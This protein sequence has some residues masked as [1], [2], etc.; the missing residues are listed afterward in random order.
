MS[1][2]PNHGHIHAYTLIRRVRKLSRPG[3][4]LKRP[5]QP[6]RPLDVVA[7]AIVPQDHHIIDVTKR[8][9]VPKDKVSRYILK[10][11][12]ETV[13]VDE[14]IAAR[15]QIAGLHR[16]MVRSPIEGEVVEV[17]GGIIILEG[18]PAIVEVKASVTGEVA[19]VLS[20]W[21]VIVET[22]GA[23]LQL[24]WA[25]GELTVS[26]LKI[27][28]PPQEGEIDPN[29]LDEMEH[30]SAVVF[31]PAPL[32]GE[33]LR[34]AAGVNAAGLVG[35][36]MD[37]GL[38]PL[39][40]ELDL[41]VGL[42]EGFGRVRMS[43]EAANLLRTNNGREITLDPG[44]SS[45]WRGSRP[46]IIISLPEDDAQATIPQ[47]DELLQVGG[48]VHLLRG[49]YRGAVGKVTALPAR[50]RRVPSGLRLMGAEVAL[51][52][53]VTTFVPFANLEHLG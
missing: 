48:R 26:Q 24:A 10:Q 53:N 36:G 41:T 28:V 49:P 34:A 17:G 19:E 9:H 11:Q 40:E 6:V 12:G 16:I 50:P 52:D 47:P 2:L 42:T 5:G 20:P 23:R 3:E 21:G 14:P 31:A 8:L 51:E 44:T 37:A 43:V 46:E 27:L 15:R 25:H 4:I 39:V 45:H 33:L 38:I 7:R 1:L 18:E 32:T 22:T 13:E 30:R 35:S 29:V